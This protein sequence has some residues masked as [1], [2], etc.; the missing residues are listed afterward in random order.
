MK[1]IAC[2]DERRGMMFNNRR[3]SRDSV[4]IADIL[5]DLGGERLYIAPYSEKLFE[6]LDVKLKVR[7]NPIRASKRDSVCFIENVSPKEYKKE[8]DEVVLYHWNRHYPAD[9]SFDLDMEGY[10]LI[11]TVELVGSSHDKITKEVWKK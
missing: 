4:V 10:T 8:I 1:I 9:F 2:L 5:N 3:Q 6:G 7:D 11:S